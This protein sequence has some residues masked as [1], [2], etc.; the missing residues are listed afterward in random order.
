VR[1]ILAP[2]RSFVLSRSF[3]G[4][5][6][7]L[8]M[9]TKPSPGLIHLLTLVLLFSATAPCGLTEVAAES[10]C[11]GPRSEPLRAV[12]HDEVGPVHLDCCAGCLTC[13][14]SYTEAPAPGTLIA[15]GA[16]VQAGFYAVQG[17]PVSPFSIWR[18]PR[19]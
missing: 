15:L 19:A 4:M 18:P 14:A 11:T 6:T 1:K 10:F 5:S 12:A 8:Q 16:A 9:N 13:C 7:P 2:Q 17:P 3:I